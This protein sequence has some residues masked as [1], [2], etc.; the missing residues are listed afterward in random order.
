MKGFKCWTP[1]I[2]MFIDHDWPKLNSK[3]NEWTMNEIWDGFEFLFCTNCRKNKPHTPYTFRSVIRTLFRYFLFLFFLIHSSSKA[4]R[5]RHSF[6]WTA[7][8]QETK[9]ETRNEKIRKKLWL[10]YYYSD[11]S[12][13]SRRAFVDAFGQSNPRHK[14]FWNFFFCRFSCFFLHL[15]L[16]FCFSSNVWVWATNYSNFY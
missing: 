12:Q 3:Q 15:F 7:I 4:K 8:I 10:Y 2:N 13:I 11:E 9:Q 1:V 16:C 6:K 5:V 14:I